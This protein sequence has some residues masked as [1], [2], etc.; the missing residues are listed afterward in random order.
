MGHYANDCPQPDR[1]NSAPPKPK[2]AVPGRAYATAL[3]EA[4]ANPDVVEGTL[5]I[6]GVLARVLF[7]SGATHS[8]SSSAF[9][10]RLP[11][12]PSRLSVSYLIETP[13]GATTI[14]DTDV[15]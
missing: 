7:D 13:I 2:P 5:L 9:G 14:V 10:K 4:L 11:V 6:S 8:F 15:F 1:R 3:Q 12:A